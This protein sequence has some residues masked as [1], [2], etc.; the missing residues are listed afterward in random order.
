MLIASSGFYPARLQPD[1][2]LNT[3]DSRGNVRTRGETARRS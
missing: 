1:I 2:S 3:T